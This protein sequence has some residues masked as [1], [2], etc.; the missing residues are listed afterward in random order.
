MH[1][2][3]RCQCAAGHAQQPPQDT[4]CS[5]AAALAHTLPSSTR[6][7]S[8]RPPFFDCSLPR[9][10]RTRT[11]TDRLAS[12]LGCGFDCVG[13]TAWGVGAHQAHEGPAT[14]SAALQPITMTATCHC[15]HDARCCCAGN[16]QR[17]HL[18]HGHTPQ[19]RELLG[20]WHDSRCFSVQLSSSAPG[21][22]LPRRARRLARDPVPPNAFNLKPPIAFKGKRQVS[23]VK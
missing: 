10:G 2:I 15:I 21:M 11:A 13:P 9:M 8:F 6:M 12:P 14:I 5:H 3:C 4:R 18:R 17:S 1:R 22:R 20:W 16:N 7:M 23:G 19:P